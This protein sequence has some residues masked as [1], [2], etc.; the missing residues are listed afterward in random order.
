METYLPL[1]AGLVGAVIGSAS[2]IIVMYIQTKVKDRRDKIQQASQ[3]AIEQFKVQFEYARLRQGQ[4]QPGRLSIAPLISYFQYYWELLEAMEDGT[5]TV[6]KIREVN[7][8]NKAVMD[9]ID[10]YDA[11]QKKP[12]K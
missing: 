10:E 1:I 4:G 12:S 6:D 8:K 5:L 9:L 7:K 11:E 3:L 2:S